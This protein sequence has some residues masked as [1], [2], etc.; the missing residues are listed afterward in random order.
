[1]TSPLGVHLFDAKASAPAPR[2]VIETGGVPLALASPGKGLLGV[3]T[4][5]AVRL[6]ELGDPDAPVLI[7][8]E[9][10]YNAAGAA[11]PISHRAA[12]AAADRL[13]WAAGAEGAVRL[14]VRPEEKAPDI[15]LPTPVVSYA[16]VAVGEEASGG[17]LIANE[18]TEPLL[19]RSI[20]IDDPAFEVIVDPDYAG[21]VE[22]FEP[23]P[24]IAI[25]PNDVGFVDIAFR[26]KKATP[27]EAV[28]TIESNDPD[29]GTLKAR[30]VGNFQRLE[31]GDEAPDVVLPA[32]DGSLHALSELRGQVV[33][34]K[35]FNGT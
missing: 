28:L 12:L 7:G 16:G 23:E 18:G 19:I 29:E 1:V 31:P 17:F 15:H 35:L 21:P 13:L 5:D 11:M 10:T 34:F 32:L 25:L 33:Y 14:L 27:V 26:A 4:W 6:Y 20:G 24:L 3:A 8:T 9:Q 30:A 2:G 22:D